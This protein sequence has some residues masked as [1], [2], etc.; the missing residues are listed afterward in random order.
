MNAIAQSANLKY[1]VIQISS[2]PNSAGRLVLSYPDEQSLRS[3]IAEPSIIA[4]GL[5]DPEEAVS[6]VVGNAPKGIASGETEQK[7]FANHHR[8]VD[9]GFAS[10]KLKWAPV[11][12]GWKHR[13]HAYSAV[14]FAFA[15]AALVLY[16]KNFLSSIIRTI[17]RI[18]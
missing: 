17:F 3:L 18:H 1:A 16:P 7:K 4:R 5:A 2:E 6:L 14:Q 11:F 9:F 15:S 10:W 8:K 13:S 12:G